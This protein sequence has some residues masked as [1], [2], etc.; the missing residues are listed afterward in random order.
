VRLARGRESRVHT[1]WCQAKAVIHGAARVYAC[2]C[3]PIYYAIR[4]C[5]VAYAL[6]LYYCVQPGSR[7]SEGR[8][9]RLA[10]FEVKIDVLHHIGIPERDVQQAQ[11]LISST[12]LHLMIA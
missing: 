10:T 6:C 4:L 7:R 3:F 11:L 8:L 5:L 2:L 9:N 12:G 1:S